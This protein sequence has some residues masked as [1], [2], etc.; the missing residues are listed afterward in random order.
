MQVS[1]AI[2]DQFR[3]AGTETEQNVLN[4]EYKL[5]SRNLEKLPRLSL[6]NLPSM[7]VGVDQ[8]EKV[9]IKKEFQF[10][11][12][13]PTKDYTIGLKS[14]M[15]RLTPRKLDP[16]NAVM[17]KSSDQIQ[18]SLTDRRSERQSPVFSE[19]ISKIKDAHTNIITRAG[20]KTKS[21]E[22]SKQIKS[23][24]IVKPNLSGR[25]GNFLFAI[26]EGHGPHGKM[27]SESIKKIFPNIIES[28]I[29]T[30]DKPEEIKIKLKNIDQDLIEILK[31]TNQEINFSSSSLLTAL[32]IKKSMYLANI[33]TCTAVLAKFNGD[34]TSNQ[35]CSRHNLKS[36]TELRRVKDL[37]A[38]IFTTTEG[39]KVF[40]SGKGPA[41][42]QTRG[43]GNLVGRGFGI[44]SEAEVLEYSLKN[45]DKFVIIGSSN[46][47]DLINYQEAVEICVE[48][49]ITKK[50]E[51]C[52]E[53]II[54]ECEDR[55]SRVSKTIS[56]VSVLVFFI[57]ST[58]Y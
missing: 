55:I 53:A 18:I 31:N 50:T 45:D 25:K 36:K 44:S 20:F 21:F 56:D 11:K 15:S 14:L 33:G 41:F 54:K 22:K 19:K 17:P 29:K 39:T 34:W 30:D 40:S 4:S 37:G 57:N 1:F 7:N 16:V 6:A 48:G 12:D 9:I 5:T 43:I 3:R 26:S 38:K 10:L 23:S 42:E 58:N 49:Y 28:K 32:I 13:S 27:V 2:I 35:L 47:W 8:Q 51:I 24:T 52:C 46:L